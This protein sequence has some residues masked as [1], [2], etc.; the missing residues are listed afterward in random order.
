MNTYEE[1]NFQEQKNNG[2]FFKYYII[3][4]IYQF[5]DILDDAC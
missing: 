3:L 1:F 2:F 4:Y 5:T